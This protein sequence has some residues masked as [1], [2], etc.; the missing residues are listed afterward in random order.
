MKNAKCPACKKVIQ[1]HEK[2]KVQELIDCPYCKSLL[3]L[4]RLY[5]PTLDWAEDPT[6]S[7]SH[8]RF[9]KIY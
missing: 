7:S 1:L 3:E 9:T 2:T 6:V 5:P 4:V 8:R